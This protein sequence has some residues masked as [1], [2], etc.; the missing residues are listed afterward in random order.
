MENKTKNIFNHH[1]IHYAQSHLTPMGLNFQLKYTTGEQNPH[2]A[3]LSR[4]DFE[5]NYGKDLITSI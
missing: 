4:L 2:A 3:V 5:Y 1:K